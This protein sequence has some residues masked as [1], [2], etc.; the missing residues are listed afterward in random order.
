[1]QL[2]TSNPD[3]HTL[4]LGIAGR[5]DAHTVTEV[6]AAWADPAHKNI[7]IDL[8]QTVFIDSMGLA[9]LVSGLKTARERGGT[10]IL[11]SVSEVTRVILELTKMHLAFTITPT[12]QEA[13]DLVTR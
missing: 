11:A 9:A 3:Q 2:T 8:S 12:V 6:K 4:L 5:F 7:V 13:L 1:M 10:L